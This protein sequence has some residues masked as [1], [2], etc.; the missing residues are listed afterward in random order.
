MIAGFLT[1]PLN[2][3]PLSAP[4]FFAPISPMDTPSTLHLASTRTRL[5]K[6]PFSLRSPPMLPRFASY[7]PICFGE[8][9]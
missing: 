1:S 2:K 9:G 7:P 8:S 6:V 5:S 4:T 3:S